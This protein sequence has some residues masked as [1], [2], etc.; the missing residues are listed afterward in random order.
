MGWIGTV[1]DIGKMIMAKALAESGSVNVNTVKIG[2]GIVAESDMRSSSDLVA[3]VG[4]GN[5]TRKKVEDGT[6]Q[7]RILITPLSSAKTIKEIG[8][9]GTYDG[10]SYL[11]ALYQNSTG[12]EIPKASTSP[13]FAYTVNA[14]WDI[15]NEEALTVTVDA[16]AI[17]TTAT[18]YEELNTVIAEEFDSTKIYYGGDVVIHGGELFERTGTNGSGEWD[19][20]KWTQRTAAELTLNHFKTIQGALTAN[21][22]VNITIPFHGPFM[23][24]VFNDG[25]ASNDGMGLYIGFCNKN[26]ATASSLKAVLGSNIPSAISISGSTLSVTMGTKGGAYRLLQIRG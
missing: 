22:T 16:S 10:D 20:T 1:T 15:D 26:S 4:T 3:Q 9:F 21:Q 19:A 14:V 17:V 23:L 12:I 7:I 6:V 18:M 24:L 11:I 5:I 8:V 25:Q 2:T 13:D